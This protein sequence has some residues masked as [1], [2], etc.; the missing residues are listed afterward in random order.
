MVLGNLLSG[1]GQAPAD[2]TERAS[3][4]ISS[5]RD[6]RFELIRALDRRER[7]ERLQQPIRLIGGQDTVLPIASKILRPRLVRLSPCGISRRT[8]SSPA[9]SL[10]DR[11]AQGKSSS[12][13]RRHRAP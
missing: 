12:P 9:V 13:R 1:L 10:A 5:V 3:G 11:R 6:P 8:G 4:K 2:Y 7:L